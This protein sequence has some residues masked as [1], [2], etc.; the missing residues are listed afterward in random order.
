MQTA[1]K[2]WDQTPTKEDAVDKMEVVNGLS[3]IVRGYSKLLRRKMVGLN[4]KPA[5]PGRRKIEE[6]LDLEDLS[7]ACKLFSETMMADVKML[8]KRDEAQMLQAW[9]SGFG[10]GRKARYVPPHGAKNL[11]VGLV[12]LRELML[13]Q[14]APTSVRIGIRNKTVEIPL[15]G[16]A[17]PMT[18]YSSN[19][20]GTGGEKMAAREDSDVP[21]GGG[22][23][24]QPDLD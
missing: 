14:R 20:T 24:K 3:Q 15:S 23:W 18:A 6:L 22:D 21:M 8:L 7:D 19:I 10:R 2:M 5:K 12:A 16:A 9:V 11:M 4:G 1:D 17:V 13:V